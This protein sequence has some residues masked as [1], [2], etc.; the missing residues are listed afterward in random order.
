[1]KLHLFEHT[2]DIKQQT[3]FTKSLTGNTNLNK[4]KLQKKLNLKTNQVICQN[5]E[6]QK[7]SL[8]DVLQNSCSQK[9]CKL[10]Q[11]CQPSGP[12]HY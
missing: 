1:M 4:Y 10:K 7:F 3:L 5:L 6:K 12:Q 9:F 2:F 11:E 8:A